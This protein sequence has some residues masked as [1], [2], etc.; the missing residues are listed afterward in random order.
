MSFENRKVRIGRVVSDKMNKTVVVQ[1]ERRKTH[2]LYK[3]S[4]RVN[5]QYKVHDT[6]NDCRIGDTVRI[7]ETRPLSKFKRWRIDEILDREDLAEIQ[8]ED[9]SIDPLIDEGNAAQTAA[10]T[11]IPESPEATQE[12]IETAPEDE[13][14]ETAPEGEPAETAP[15]DEP[16]ETAPED[17]P[18]ADS[19]LNKE[20]K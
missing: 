4:I 1:V 12:N 15:E 11:N 16:A 3:K 10:P 5:N 18:A 9:I 14:A 6:E 8:P 20:K 19:E 2:S 17:E 7:I 13:L